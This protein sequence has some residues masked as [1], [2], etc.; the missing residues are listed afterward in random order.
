MFGC[1]RNK[2]KKAKAAQKTDIEEDLPQIIH[3]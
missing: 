2:N 1:R 3:R